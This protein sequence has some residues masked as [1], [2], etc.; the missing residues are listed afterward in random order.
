MLGWLRVQE[1]AEGI[2]PRE[3]RCATMQVQA[4]PP[5]SSSREI[6]SRTR[7]ALMAEGSSWCLS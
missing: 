2:S 4:S 3:T 6:T 7:L 5:Y 1:L